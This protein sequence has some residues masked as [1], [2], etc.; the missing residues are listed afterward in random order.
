MEV[1]GTGLGLWWSLWFHSTATKARVLSLSSIP[2]GGE[3]RGEEV[4]S[5]YSISVAVKGSPRSPLYNARRRLSLELSLR[6]MTAGATFSPVSRRARRPAS[7]SSQLIT[8]FMGIDGT[9][10]SESCGGFINKFSNFGEVIVFSTARQALDFSPIHTF[11]PSPPFAMEE[12][13]G[14]R[15]CILIKV[16]PIKKR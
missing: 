8:S 6:R 11:S 5:N 2:N 4:H 13:A 7:Q 14:E 16:C 10:L 9:P 15:R 3:G 12:R 1:R